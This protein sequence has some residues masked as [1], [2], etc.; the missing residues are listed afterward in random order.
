MTEHDTLARLIQET[1]AL[2][3]RM[4]RLEEEGPGKYLVV[5]TRVKQLQ[6]ALEDAINGD[7]VSGPPAPFW[8]D[9]SDYEHQAQMT[10]L[11]DWVSGYL[12]VQYPGYWLPACWPNHAEAVMELA[13]LWCEWRRIYDCAASRRDLAAA[14]AWH[15]RWY[16]GVLAR[17]QR[18][19]TCDVSGCTVTRSQPR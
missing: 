19:V 15:D 5:L 16:P 1:A 7:K 13:T 17:L 11:Q 10:A 14:L 6:D 9:L 3:A 18:A 12:R 8:L 2:R 4:V